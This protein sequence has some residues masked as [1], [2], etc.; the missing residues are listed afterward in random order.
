ML[1]QMFLQQPKQPKSQIKGR[2]NKRLSSQLANC[3]KPDQKSIN[4]R[5]IKKKSL[6]SLLWRVSGTFSAQLDFS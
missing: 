5:D 4:F 6:K 1:R 3:L 2:T